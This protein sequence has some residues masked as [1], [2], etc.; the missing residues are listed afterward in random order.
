LG[1]QF[2]IKLNSDNQKDLFEQ[3]AS[4]QEIFV[5]NNCCI[6]GSEEVYFRTRTIDGN[7]F[8]E[9]VCGK[10]NKTFSYGQNKKG[11]TLFPKGPWTK[12]EPSLKEE[13]DNKVF[14]E[15]RIKK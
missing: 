1:G 5:R 13:D 2:T 7:N 12:W 4:F 3:L 14:T 6:C 15:G 11:D 10:C 9:K 8:Y